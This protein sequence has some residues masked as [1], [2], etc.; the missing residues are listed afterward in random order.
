[1][2]RVLLA[3][4]A[5][6]FVGAPLA[7]AQPSAADFASAPAMV[8]AAI[9]PDG[10]YIIALQSIPGGQAIVLINWRQRQ[11]Q[12]LRTVS[13]ERGMFLEG[14]AW[15]G[16]DRVLFWVRQRT[17]MVREGTGSRNRSD[18][19]EIDVVRIFASDRNGANLTQLFENNRL[20]ARNLSVMLID[21]LE[22]DPEHVL[23]G[24]WGSA[25]FTLYRVD[26][27]NG[28][29]AA[30]EDAAWETVG[31]LVNRDGRAI[32]RMDALPYG[33]GYRY[34]RRP[35]S[36]G[37]WTVAHEVRRQRTTQNRDFFPIEAGPGPS[38]VYVAARPE[39]QEYQAIYLYDTSTGEL[40]QPVFAYPNADAAIMRTSRADNTLLYACAET[41]RYQCTAT[42]RA[43][44]RH[45]DGLTGY[46]ENRADFSVDSS[47]SDGRFWLVNA[48]GPTVPATFYV[49]DVAAAQMTPIGQ[50]HPNISRSALSDSRVVNYTSRDGVALWGYLT[51][52]ARGQGPFPTV[53][54]PHGGPEARDSYGFD[55]IVQFLVSRG[56]AVFQPNFRGSEGSGRSFARAG[57][58]QWGGVM[59]NDITDGVEHLIS[60]GVANRDR[61]CIAGIS[62]GGYAALAGAALTPDLYKCAISIAGISDLPEFLDSE[63]TDAGRRSDS[64]AYW[65][66]IMGDPGDSRDQLIA[67]SP[68]RHVD[69]I[70]VPI[71]LIH[72]EK[73]DITLASQSERM[74]DALQRAGKEVR[75][76]EIEGNVYHPWDGWTTDHARQL[77]VEME[78]FLGSHIGSGAQQ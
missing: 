58:R 70:H 47:S 65:R 24:T 14:V 49:Y 55:F 25:G 33:S 78:T 39:G 4:M 43:M 12:Q 71:L 77:L 22:N 52:P 21:P 67:G 68:R 60:T 28:R 18:A 63:R 32:M 20:A 10:N 9:S 13:H 7:A 64:Y 54:M 61:I 51:T 1:M 30:V 62:Y 29:T 69:Q 73:D 35:A 36:G 3:V 53:I 50:T 59:Q 11:A 41:Q 44:Q 6:L 37:R 48:W 57:Y 23:L 46:F 31:M 19:G 15:K 38:Q 26:V 42:D 56:Y 17:M 76:V 74:R 40:G 45:L 5:F 34:Y 16:N 2:L 27:S 72:G 66:E 8:G 75:Y